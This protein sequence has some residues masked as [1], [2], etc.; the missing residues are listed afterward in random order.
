LYASFWRVSRCPSSARGSTACSPRT[1]GC[2]SRAPWGRWWSSSWRPAA[3]LPHVDSYLCRRGAGLV[4]YWRSF[5]RLERFSRDRGFIHL[6]ARKR[7]NQAAGGDGSVGIW[8][9][10]FLRAGQCRSVY[11]DMP[12]RGLGM[13]GE[14]AQAVGVLGAARR[15]LQPRREASP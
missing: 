5:E 7:F 3:G 13:A 8:H 10:T 15:R 4:R 14:P 1:S 9:E 12:R 11:I 2:P 6:G